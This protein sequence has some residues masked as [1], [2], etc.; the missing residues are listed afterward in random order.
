MASNDTFIV[1]IGASAGGLEAIREL[2]KNLPVDIDA[3][4]VVVQHMSPQ[5]RSLLTTLI[6]RETH[7]DVVDI[8]DG[9]VPKANT[10]YVTPP[11]NDVIYRDGMLNLQTPNREIA[12][13]KPS[14]DRFFISIAE[15]AGERAV[16]IVLSGTGSDGAYGVQ[17]IR[18]AG[19][20]TITQD[21][22]TAKYDGMPT[23]AVETGCVDLVLSPIEIGTHLSKI[24]ASPRDLDQFRTQHGNDHPLSDL[25]QILLARTRVDFRDYKQTTVQRRI[26]RRMNALDMPNQ[27]TYTAYCRSNPKEVDAL[28]KDLLISVTRFFRDPK[29]FSG[30]LPLLEK[31]L[32]NREGPLRV[33][34]AGCATGEEVYSIGILLGE[35]LGGIDKL[36]KEKV[37]IFASDIDKNA[38][39]IAR[40]GHYSL[41]AVDDVPADYVASY[42]TR[43]EDGVV[44]SQVL[45]DITLFSEHNICQDP[46]FLNIDLVCCRNL[47]IYFGGSLQDRVLARLHYAMNPEGLLFLGTAETV[48]G[49]DHLFVGASDKLHIYQK[50]RLAQGERNRTSALVGRGYPTSVNT[51]RAGKTT[52]ARDS[53]DRAMFDAMARTLGKSAML[54]SNDHRILRVY[55]DMSGLVALTEETRLQMTVSMLRNPIAQE[56]R[57][58]ATLAIKNGTRRTGLIHRTGDAALQ[59]EAIPISSSEIEEDMALLVFDEWHETPPDDALPD[60]VEGEAAR[61]QIRTLQGELASTRD[62]LQQTIEELET[63]NEELRSLNEELQSTNE[64]LQAT[65]EELETS[66]EELQSTNEELVTVNEELHI[67]SAELAA[68]SDELSSI[69]EHLAVP[70]MVVDTALQV[71]KAS[72]AAMQLFNLTAPMERPH[73]SQIEV[74]KGFPGLA[75]V[76]NETIRLGLVSEQVIDAEGGSFVLHIAPQADSKGRIV[77]ATLI[78]MEGASGVPQGLQGLPGPVDGGASDAVTVP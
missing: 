9:I 43:S 32:A 50:R 56:A 42:F 52:P 27:P 40:R 66:N 70:V 4:Y 24:L 72:R 17:A 31:K 55:G 74:P 26:E 14:V 35:A 39:Q 71:S 61:E 73:V 21:E 12:T 44:V 59:L 10:I 11:N 49:S 8:D 57:L 7:L 62:S 64:E 60:A 19:G 76:C 51:E 77:G 20:I 46:P 5:H 45:R 65:N 58:L 2:V 54:L 18:G 29:E 37:Q 22:S 23:S 34:V 15:S 53:I 48:S 69:L 33:W 1:G 3:C 47:L 38:L 25:L 63:S 78:F 13:P 6:D 36:R 28:F 67:N 41:V 30:L 75:E 16:G 68:L